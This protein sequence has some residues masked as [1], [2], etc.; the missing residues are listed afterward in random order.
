MMGIVVLSGGQ[1]ADL[2]RR[3]GF[4]NT[5]NIR[6]LFTCTGLLN[7]HQLREGSLREHA[8]VEAVGKDRRIN[9]ISA[10]QMLPIF[11]LKYL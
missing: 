8:H 7:V 2:I 9:L 1:L 5:T 10:Q 3:H 6:K 4:L 11:M